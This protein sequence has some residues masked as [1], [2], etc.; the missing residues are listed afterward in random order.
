[1]NVAVVPQSQSCIGQTTLEVFRGHLTGITRETQ[2]ILL[3]SC[4]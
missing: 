2:V 3:K 1:M 4:N